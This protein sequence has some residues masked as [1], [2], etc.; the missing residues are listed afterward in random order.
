MV[1]SV[2]NDIYFIKESKDLNLYD[3]VSRT[4]EILR[5]CLP[6]GGSKK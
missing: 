2:E 1:V 4:S 5:L 3:I 6:K